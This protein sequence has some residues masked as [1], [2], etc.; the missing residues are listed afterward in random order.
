MTTAFAMFNKYES[1][2]TFVQKRLTLNEQAPRVSQSTAECIELLTAY[3]V[4]YAR[5]CLLLCHVFD[6]PQKAGTFSWD[7]TP[8]T[9][10]SKKFS[11][12]GS[13]L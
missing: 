11:N 4:G 10:G 13:D 6:Q 3:F 9:Q 8:V 12:C 1:N 2:F 5:H 7:G